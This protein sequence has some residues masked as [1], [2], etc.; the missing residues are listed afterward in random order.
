MYIYT[1]KKHHYLSSTVDPKPISIA[2]LGDFS[3][4]ADV[5]IGEAQ[6]DRFVEKRS[7][8]LLG[9]CKLTPVKIFF[10]RVTR[11]PSRIRRGAPFWTRPTRLFA[12]G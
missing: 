9:I 11:V 10:V 7:V 1:K 4:S 8:L 3:S 5:V 6:K 12:R 2:L